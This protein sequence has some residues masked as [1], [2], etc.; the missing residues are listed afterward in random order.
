MIG[1]PINML[2]HYRGLHA[3]T[4]I[5]IMVFQLDSMYVFCVRVYT[6]MCTVQ[7]A[8]ALIISSLYHNSQIHRL[9]DFKQRCHWNLFQSYM[10][11]R[12]KHIECLFMTARLERCRQ[13]RWLRRHRI[14]VRIWSD[15]WFVRLVGVTARWTCVQFFFVL[16]S[17]WSSLSL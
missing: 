11:M 14:Q 13:C 15:G 17:S 9:L 4:C 3:V 12:T 1:W 8:R 7:Y 10:F 2:L 6:H 16:T 5:L